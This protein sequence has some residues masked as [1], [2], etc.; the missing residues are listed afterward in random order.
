M[1]AVGECVGLSVDAFS[2]V[3]DDDE[4]PELWLDVALP[5]LDQRDGGEQFLVDGVLEEVAVGACSECLANVAGVVVDR[6]HE[7]LR[8]GGGGAEGGKGVETILVAETNVE[9]DQGR[10]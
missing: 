1:L 5:G 2:F 10:L 3:G 8:I 7:H 6:E 4:G 9:N